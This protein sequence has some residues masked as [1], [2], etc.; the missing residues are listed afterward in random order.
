LLEI[1]EAG[2]L[3]LE[4]TQLTEEQYKPFRPVS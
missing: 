4:R 1:R 3:S 2:H